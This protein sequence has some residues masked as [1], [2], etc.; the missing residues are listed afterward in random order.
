M[1]FIFTD[2][3]TEVE[4]R[5]GHKN[6]DGA[7]PNFKIKY[8][9]IFVGLIL[10]D[11]PQWSSPPGVYTLC[12]PCPQGWSVR[13]IEL[14]STAPRFLFCSLGS[15]TPEKATNISCGHSDSP[16]RGPR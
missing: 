15:L 14:V 8:H 9:V 6:L 16:E 11:G 4:M 13:P 7:T 2:E 5:H 12:I 3:Q 10:Q 1:F